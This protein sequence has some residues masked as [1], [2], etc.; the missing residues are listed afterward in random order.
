M[1]GV[2]DRRWKVYKDPGGPVSSRWE[3][4]AVDR[5][6]ALEDPELAARIEEWDKDH[7]VFEFTTFDMVSDSATP[8]AHPPC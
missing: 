2:L 8:G 6:A 7:P 4:S 1:S 5:L 3:P